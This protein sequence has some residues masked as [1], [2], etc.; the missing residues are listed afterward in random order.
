MKQNNK[1]V[2][3]FGTQIET[4]I[5]ELNTLQISKAGEE[6]RE[7]VTNVN[8]IFGL[9]AFKTGLNDSLKS[10]IF[11]ARPKTLREAL[12]LA[13]EVTVVALL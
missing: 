12:Q 6:G 4:L 5:S 13:A 7:I 2:T 10:T 8:D 3:E 1:S 9:N 11:A